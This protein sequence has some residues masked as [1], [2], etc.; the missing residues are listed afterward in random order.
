MNTISVVRKSPGT[1]NQNQRVP[2][3]QQQ[4][5]Q[6]KFLQQQSP[7]FGFKLFFINIDK[8]LAQI[9]SLLSFKTFSETTSTTSTTPTTTTTTTTSTTTDFVSTTSTEKKSQ[10]WKQWD[11]RSERSDVDPKAGLKKTLRV[12]DTVKA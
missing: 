1:E 11:I 8:S 10:K 7:L 6:L 5:Q 12:R 9:H 3:R 4:L 2:Q